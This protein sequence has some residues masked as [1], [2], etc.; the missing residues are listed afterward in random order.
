LLT[1]NVII[2][3]PDPGNHNENQWLPTR[4]AA[5]LAPYPTLPSIAEFKK[6][7]WRLSGGSLF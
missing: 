6:S 5:G 4:A 3:G 2:G 1:A 7:G